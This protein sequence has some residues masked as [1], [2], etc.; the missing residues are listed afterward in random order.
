VFQLR[1]YLPASPDGVTTQKTNDIFITVRTS[2]HVFKC[3]YM[4]ILKYGVETW[5][6]TKADINR[7]MTSEMKFLRSTEGKTKRDGIRNEKNYRIQR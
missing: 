1:R 4:P 5:T 7:L 6:W 3:Y 2:N